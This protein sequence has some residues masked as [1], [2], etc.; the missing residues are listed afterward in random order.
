MAAFGEARV[1]AFPP[2]AEPAAERTP[3]LGRVA[4][5]FAIRHT[6]ARAFHHIFL[7]TFFQPQFD[8]AECEGRL[9]ARAVLV[10]F[11]LAPR[12]RR[13]FVDTESFAA[14]FLDDALVPGALVYA[15]QHVVRL[16]VGQIG[17]VH[18]QGAVLQATLAGVDKGRNIELDVRAAFVLRAARCLPAGV[19]DLVFF[20]RRH[21][22][23]ISPWLRH[24]VRVLHVE[25]EFSVRDCTQ[26][27]ARL[28]QDM[29]QQRLFLGQH[30]CNWKFRL[31]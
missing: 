20:W 22:F 24:R 26:Q 1:L 31:A 2:G 7:S 13:R 9:L 28:A 16:V 6:E 25:L 8:T 10:R 29:F 18:L 15:L 19:V 3:A 11:A 23:K 17:G 14:G 30:S 5:F 21:P 27:A 4:G 12:Q